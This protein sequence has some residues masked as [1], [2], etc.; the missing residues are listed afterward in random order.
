M[1]SKYDTPTNPIDRFVDLVVIRSTSPVEPWT[2]HSWMIMRAVAVAFLF[3]MPG[4][5]MIN[6][7]FGSVGLIVA[8]ANMLITI[9]I[10]STRF[11][12]CAVSHGPCAKHR[13]FSCQ[14]IFDSVR[15]G[16]D[17]PHCSGSSI[18][19]SENREKCQ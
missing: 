15:H 7:G 16:T 10:M 3:A 2:S 19:S 5:Y 18:C 13:C 6:Q 4:L 14:R 1:S 8:T 9:N 17:C 11:N 12:Q